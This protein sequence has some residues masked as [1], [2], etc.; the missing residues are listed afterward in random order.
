MS[1]HFDDLSSPS[2]PAG[3]LWA[4]CDNDC[5]GHSIV[6]SLPAEGGGGGFQEVAR[7]KRPEGMS[8]INNEGFVIFPDARCHAA[9]GLRGTLWCDDSASQGHAFRQG[10]LP[11]GD[12]VAASHR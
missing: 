12:F 2:S 11:C 10:T 3:Y 4:Q 5:K 9:S 8:N 6:F 1:L 7:Y